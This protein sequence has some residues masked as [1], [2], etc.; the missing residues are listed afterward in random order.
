[1]NMSSGGGR[2]FNANA[3]SVRTFNVTVW[4][5]FWNSWI[6]GQWEVKIGGSF[7]WYDGSVNFPILKVS[8]KSPLAWFAT[9]SLSSECF[10]DI[11]TS[12]S[13]RPCIQYW[14]HQ[15]PEGI[16]S[17]LQVVFE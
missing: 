9:S 1:M 16:H 11:N 12:R 14:F 3:K 5:S 6:S 2:T 4:H 13:S 10:T 17:S 15:Y 8:L 7:C